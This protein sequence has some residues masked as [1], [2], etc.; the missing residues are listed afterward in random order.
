MNLGGGAFA[1]GAAPV[2]PQDDAYHF[3]SFADGEHD[4]LYA[5]WWYFNLIDPEHDLQAIFAYSV[6]DPAN[7]SRLG[8]ASVL[9]VVYTPGGTVQHSPVPSRRVL[10]L[11]PR[12]P[13]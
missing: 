8:L 12:R 7:R 2:T 13:T 9:G 1:A 3:A 5:E 4:G 10:P 11:R 6:V